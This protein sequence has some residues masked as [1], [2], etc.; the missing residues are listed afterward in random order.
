MLR[1]PWTTLAA[2]FFLVLATAANAR[3]QLHFAQTTIDAG[4]LYNG[5][6]LVR[7]FEFINAGKH[8]VDIIEAK[9]SCA[10]ARPS[11]SQRSLQPGEKGWVELEVHTLGQPPGP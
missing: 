6:P 3:A 7:K 1:Q 8:P 5:Q 2:P 11:L 10:C 4:T 9:A